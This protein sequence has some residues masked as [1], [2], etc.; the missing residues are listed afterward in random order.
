MGHNSAVNV[1]DF[2]EKYIVSASGDRRIKIWDTMNG[3]LLR[4]L[5]GHE[6]GIACLQYRDGLIISGG[7]DNSIR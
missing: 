2:D 1:I 7:S 4:T 5:R 3:T 6:R